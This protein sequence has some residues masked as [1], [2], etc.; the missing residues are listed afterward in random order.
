MGKRL[1][2]GLFCLFCCV[3]AA[4]AAEAPALSAKAWALAD[5]DSGR[6]LAS[7]RAEEELAIA[8]ITKI[9]TAVVVL[10]RTEDLDRLVSVPAGAV[11]AEGSSMYLKAGEELTVRELLYGLLLVSGNDAAMALAEICGGTVEEF[12]RWMNEKAAALGMTHT[13]FANP[14]G[15]SET[16]HYSSAGDMVLLTA[17]AMKRPEFAEIVATRSITAAGRT[18]VNHNKLLRLY[19]GAVGVKTGYTKE[20]GRTLVSCARREGSGLVAVT[21]CDPDD[22]RDHGALLDFG[23]DAFPVTELCPAGKVLGRVTAGGAAVP[24]RAAEQVSARLGKEERFTAE[25]HLAEGIS[26]PISAGAIAGK[27]IFYVNGTQVGQTYVLFERA[28]AA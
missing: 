20:A 15:L 2:A 26:P 10:E 25:L 6:I 22:W 23:F 27:A 3:S 17:Y 28:V 8:S 12:V 7:S 14:S 21:L 5:E 4:G 16:G 24:L 9:M 11:G 18:L 1:L 19:P 13:H